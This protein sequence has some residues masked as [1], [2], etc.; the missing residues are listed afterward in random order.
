MPLRHVVEAAYVYPERFVPFYAPDP[1]APG[2]LER[3]EKAVRLY[4]VRGCGELK[5]RVMLNNLQALEMFHFCGEAGLPVIFHMD[6]PCPADWLGGS[7][8]YWYCAGWDEL[9]KALESCPQTVFL[10]HAPGF[11]RGISGDADAE[12]VM[13]PKGPVTPGGRVVDYLERYPNLYCDLSAGSG[14]GALSRDP[15]FGASFLKRWWDRCLFARDSFG[16]ELHEFI[17]G[18]KLPQ[19]AYRAIMGGNAER[20]VG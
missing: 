17:R 4:G 9:A 11:W 7:P 15:E 19:K 3:L 14:L 13:Y 8:G 6:L 20:L 2:A 16:G 5:V 18:C 10:G 12:E 1:R